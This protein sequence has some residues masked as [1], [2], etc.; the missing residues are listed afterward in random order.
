VEPPWRDVGGGHFYRCHVP[1]AELRQ[2]QLTGT[3]PDAPHVDAGSG[4]AA[5][6]A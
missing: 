2:L 4:P 6:K 3:S 1:E 5:G